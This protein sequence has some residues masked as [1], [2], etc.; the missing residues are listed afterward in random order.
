MNILKNDAKPIFI[1][2]M[3]WV[4]YRLFRRTAPNKT[5]TNQ[6]TNMNDKYFHKL[7][8]FAKTKQSAWFFITEI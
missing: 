6:E 3:W 8:K 7:S 2:P 5:N 1:F 4:C